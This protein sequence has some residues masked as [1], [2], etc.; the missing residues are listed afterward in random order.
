MG[1]AAFGAWEWRAVDVTTSVEVLHY[2]SWTDGR[3]VLTPCVVVM[4][5]LPKD[6]IP[7]V[8]KALMR[9]GRLT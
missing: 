9:A 6:R 7:H 2:L 5:T 8:I 1:W 3:Y 4:D